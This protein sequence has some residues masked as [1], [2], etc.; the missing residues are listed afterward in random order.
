MG[1]G[2]LVLL[3]TLGHTD[4]SLAL[5]I[6]RGAPAHDPTAAARLLGS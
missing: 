3:A 2:S 6:R 1:D 4:G 5:L